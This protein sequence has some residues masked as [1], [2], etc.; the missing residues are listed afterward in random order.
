MNTAIASAAPTP[1]SF[2]DV[3]LITTAHGLT[4]WYVATLYILLPL[5]GKEFGLSYTEIGLIMTTLHLVSAISNVR[6]VFLVDTVGRKGYLMAFALF[7]VSFPYALMSMD[8][9]L[10]M[11]LICVALVGMGNNLSHPTAIPTLAHRYPERKSLV[12]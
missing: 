7:W 12:L 5:I 8:H 11:L 2:R 6:G 9:G 4:H 1:K 3:W 10:W